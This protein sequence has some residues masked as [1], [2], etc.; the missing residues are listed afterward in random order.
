MSFLT[1]ILGIDRIIR[2]IQ[3][4][5]EELEEEIQENRG[6]VEDTKEDIT[7]EVQEIPYEVWK[8]YKDINQVLEE[9][10]P[11]RIMNILENNNGKMNVSELRNVCKEKGICSKNTFY[12]KLEKLKRKSLIVE[13][14]EGRKKYV[15]TSAETL[16]NLS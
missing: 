14:R 11:K 16:L 10:V 6:V 5:K 12:K 2:E 9:T 4:V 1:K 7:Q 13:E 8:Q 3:G 15:R